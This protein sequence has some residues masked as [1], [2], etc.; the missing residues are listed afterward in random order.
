MF[1]LKMNFKSKMVFD[2]KLDTKRIHD[3]ELELDHDRLVW[4]K[5]KRA[6][7]NSSFEPGTCIRI[8]G[9]V[10]KTKYNGMLAQVKKLI[11]GDTYRVMLSSQK[12]EIAI[13]SVCLYLIGDKI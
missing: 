9:C 6:S 2:P 11:E 4:H 12:T 1:T 10:N 13:Q 7:T 5:V 8:V 3:L